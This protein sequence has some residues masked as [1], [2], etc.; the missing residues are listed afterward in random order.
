METLLLTLALLA[1]AVLAGSKAGNAVV[2]WCLRPG[3]AERDR[4]D[5]DPDLRLRE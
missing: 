4:H 3:P 2:A 1:L 5:T